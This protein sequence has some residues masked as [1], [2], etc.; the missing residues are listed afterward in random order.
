MLVIRIMYI[1][2]NNVLCQNP[3]LLAASCGNGCLATSEVRNFSHETR[4]HFGFISENLEQSRPKIL[5]FEISSPHDQPEARK[6]CA[7]SPPRMDQT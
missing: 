1:M 5:N 4:K 2:L 7:F 3:I 6:P